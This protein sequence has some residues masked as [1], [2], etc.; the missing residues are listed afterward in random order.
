MGE[1]KGQVILASGISSPEGVE[2]SLGG[3]QAR[4]GELGGVSVWEEQ[5]VWGE[6]RGFRQ[7]P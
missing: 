3:L 1:F 2:A 4:Q 6:D 5:A 7:P